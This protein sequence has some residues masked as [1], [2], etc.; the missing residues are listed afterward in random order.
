[1][2]LELKPLRLDQNCAVNDF[3]N[4]KNVSTLKDLM[5]PELWTSSSYMHTPMLN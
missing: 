4:P 1:M 5:T 3:P 2:I